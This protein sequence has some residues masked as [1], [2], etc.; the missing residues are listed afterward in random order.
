[1]NVNIEEVKKILLNIEH[2]RNYAF[3]YILNELSNY[4]IVEGGIRENSTIS[5]KPEDVFIR[6][7]TNN[8]NKKEIPNYIELIDE[9]ANANSTLINYLIARNDYTSQ[10]TLAKITAS[11]NINE[12]ILLEIVKHTDEF[13]I[14]EEVFNKGDN[15][16]KIAILNKPSFKNNPESYDYYLNSFPIFNNEEYE[17]LDPKCIP[18]SLID[19]YNK[20]NRIHYL[21]SYIEELEETYK[22]Y[23]NVG[24]QAL[25]ETLISDLNKAKEEL[26]SMTNNNLN[27]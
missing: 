13:T 22:T 19:Q 1:M 3:N 25:L 18:E 24:N 27:M 23:A 15:K 5:R 4:G 9:L 6:Y 11:P 8:I 16:I 17:Q 21:E 14:L 20:Y 12:S 7:L 10:S 26:N 2:E